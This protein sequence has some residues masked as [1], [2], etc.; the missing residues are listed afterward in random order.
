MRGGHLLSVACG[1]VAPQNEY[2]ASGFR[3]MGAAGIAS[4]GLS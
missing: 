4:G 1:P 2:S 3:H